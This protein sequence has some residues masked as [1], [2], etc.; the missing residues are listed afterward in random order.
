M[1]KSEGDKN[2][3]RNKMIC[4]KKKKKRALISCF[5]SGTIKDFKPF[6]TPANSGLHWMS[7]GSP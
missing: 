1:R 2:K 7:W 6:C 3:G 4:K 5:F